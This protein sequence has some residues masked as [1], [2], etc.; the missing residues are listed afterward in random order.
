MIQFFKSLIAK[1]KEKLIRRM[2]KTIT[3]NMTPVK[4]TII[5]LERYP[6][7]KVKYKIIIKNETNRTLMLKV[8]NKVTLKQGDRIQGYYSKEDKT[9]LIQVA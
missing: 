2:A 1:I 4:G 6:K 7:G 5:Y 3:E 8:K 9:A